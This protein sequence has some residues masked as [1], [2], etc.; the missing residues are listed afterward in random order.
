[1]QDK[2]KELTYSQIRL[3]T[4]INPSFARRSNVGRSGQYWPY[5]L[6]L[7]DSVRLSNRNVRGAIS[8]RGFLGLPQNG[9]SYH[10]VTLIGAQCQS[11]CNAVLAFEIPLTKPHR[12]SAKVSNAYSCFAEEGIVLP[13][14]ESDTAYK[15]SSRTMRSQPVISSVYD[16]K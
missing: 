16:K 10:D 7:D 1:M 13:A 11:S 4:S 2:N 12:R 9:I 8:G 3:R 15:F 14:Q 6:A 5:K